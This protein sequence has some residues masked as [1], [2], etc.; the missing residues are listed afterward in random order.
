M[1]KKERLGTLFSGVAAIELK[2]KKGKRIP[3]LQRDSGAPV[4]A[5]KYTLPAGRADK[6]INNVTNEELL[7]EMVFF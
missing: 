3:L 2:T 5:G 4:D 1:R 6:I 7:E